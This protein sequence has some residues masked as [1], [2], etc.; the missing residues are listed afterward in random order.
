MYESVDSSWTD[1]L[2]EFPPIHGTLKGLASF[3]N[4]IINY[5]TKTVEY[6]NVDIV[7]LPNDNGFLMTTFLWV[8]FCVFWP[9]NRRYIGSDC[10]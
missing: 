2:K 1:L 5:L 10:I 6:I 8:R 3:S 7:V 4:L 9:D